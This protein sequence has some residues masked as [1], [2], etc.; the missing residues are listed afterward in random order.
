MIRIANFILSCNI[1][2]DFIL[3]EDIITDIEFIKRN[4]IKIITIPIRK[5]ESSIF[6]LNQRVCVR[7]GKFS[8]RIPIR[9]FD[10]ELNCSIT[11]VDNFIFVYAAAIQ[12]CHDLW[13]S[14]LAD[15]YR[16]N[17]ITGYERDIIV[18]K[19][20]FFDVKSCCPATASSSDYI[21]IFGHIFIF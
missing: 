13:K 14:G 21:N 4:F 10:S 18:R 15:S 17:I 2:H 20:I 6:L 5:W 1:L 3:L 9:K 7:K 12:K 8:K 11:L 16:P 19:D